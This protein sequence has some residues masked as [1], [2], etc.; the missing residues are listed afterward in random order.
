MKHTQPNQCRYLQINPLCMRDFTGSATALTHFVWLRAGAAIEK[1]P[2][3]NRGVT[4]VAAD[5]SR[6]PCTRALAKQ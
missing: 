3:G 5:D 4:G 2:V 6:Q 1:M